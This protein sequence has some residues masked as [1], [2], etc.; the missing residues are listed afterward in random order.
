MVK[1]NA[2]REPPPVKTAEPTQGFLMALHW[3]HGIGENQHAIPAGQGMLDHGERMGI[4]KRLP[5]GKADFKKLR[6]C[7]FGFLKQ[8]EELG[9]REIGKPVV[10]R[11]AFD[12]AAGASDIAKRARVEPKR[13]Q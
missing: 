4:E 6:V 2:H 11:A 8:A 5:T 12:I 10:A 3:P 13:F 9:E 1:R 7:G